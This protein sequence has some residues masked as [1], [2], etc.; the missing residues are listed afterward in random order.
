MHTSAPQ[1]QPDPT[2]E[3]QLQ[4][5]Q[6]AQQKAVS[7][8]LSADT[9]QLLRLF[10]QQNAVSGAGMSMPMQSLTSIKAR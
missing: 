6:S 9:L 1:P 8:S 4:L 10:G 5:A 2:L 7:Q 3:A